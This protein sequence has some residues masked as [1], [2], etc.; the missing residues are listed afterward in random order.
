[1]AQLGNSLRLTLIQPRIEKAPGRLPWQ[2]KIQDEDVWLKWRAEARWRQG[3]EWVQE[4]LAEGEIT[5]AE[6][7]WWAQWFAAAGAVSKFP[8]ALG[9][10]PSDP[11]A[12]LWT[13]VAGAGVEFFAW[14]EPLGNLVVMAVFTPEG[15][16]ET[17]CRRIEATV[18]VEDLAAFGQALEAEYQ[19]LRREVAG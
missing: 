14:P 9:D 17:E 12:R 11:V 8:R 3:V 10:V 16:G 15:A 19:A 2:K 13:P 4:V 1:M 7:K 5:G 18:S 6:V